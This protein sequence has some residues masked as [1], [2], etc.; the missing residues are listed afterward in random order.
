MEIKQENNEKG[1]RFVAYVD[2]KEAGIMTYTWPMEDKFI[3]DHTEVYD[4]FE[5]MGIGKKLVTQAV[6]YA[7]EHNKKII[8]VC[9]FAKSVIQKVVALQDV[10]A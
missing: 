6:V 2:N 7:R 8:P 1:G 5:G 4:G 10:L 3:I 9:P